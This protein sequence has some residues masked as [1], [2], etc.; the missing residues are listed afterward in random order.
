[1]STKPYDQAFKFLAERDAE[2]LL[3]L[4]GDMQPGQ[5]AEI[6]V[7][8]REVSISTQLPDQPYEVI[9]SGGRRL[10]HVEAQTAYDANLPERMLEYAI[11]LW[12]KYRLPISSY[13][14]L[15]TN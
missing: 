11:R 14:L 1:M 9:T 15:L 2:A 13:A 8:P 7:L 3:L 5:E 4:L 10:V 6:R 12:L